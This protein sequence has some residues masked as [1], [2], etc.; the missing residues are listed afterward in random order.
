M[1]TTNSSR[2]AG[3]ATVLRPSAGRSPEDHQKS[4]L[5]KSTIATRHTHT[6]ER[7]CRVSQSVPVRTS[8]AHMPMRDT[9]RC[10]LRE[11]RSS[12]ICADMW[13]LGGTR[14]MHAHRE[15]TGVRGHLDRP[16]RPPRP[17]RSCRRGSR[18][19][20]SPHAAT[21]MCARGVKRRSTEPLTQKRPRGSSEIRGAA[22][23]DPFS[24]LSTRVPIL[25]SIPAVR[26][27]VVASRI[28]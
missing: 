5:I 19:V 18:R 8:L 23:S 11:S 3:R 14:S 9:P 6:A 28:R 7:P 17:H 22:E 4:L 27:M 12:S 1:A 15:R 24:R 25:F 16:R 20:G 21:G 26:R 13:V 2:R 10:L